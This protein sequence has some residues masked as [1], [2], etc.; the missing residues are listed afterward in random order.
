[1]HLKSQN[2]VMFLTGRSKEELTII[3]ELVK[4]GK[5]THIIDR[6]YRLDEL[7]EAIRYLETDTREGK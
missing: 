3:H 7:P 5:M 2:L 1:M 6:R 4:A